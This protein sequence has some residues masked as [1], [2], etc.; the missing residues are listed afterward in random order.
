[1]M[2]YVHRLTYFGGKRECS[3]QRLCKLTK[4]KTHRIK[5]SLEYVQAQ[6]CNTASSYQRLPIMLKKAYNKTISYSLL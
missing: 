6:H 3:A 5:S 4:L 1:M 2:R